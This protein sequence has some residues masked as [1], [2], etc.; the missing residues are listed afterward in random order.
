MSAQL[1]D[2][3]LPQPALH[4]DGLKKGD[5]AFITGW[6]PTVHADQNAIKIRLQELGFVPGEKIRIVAHA[7]PSGDPIAVRLGNTTFALRRYEASLVQ[8]ESA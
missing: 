8:V 3:S 2:S 7:F 1:T 6:A 4:L 5:R